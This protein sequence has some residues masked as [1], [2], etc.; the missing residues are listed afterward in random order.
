MK[1]C[2]SRRRLRC[3]IGRSARIG[4]T[5]ICRSA[6]GSFRGSTRC[7]A[8][9]RMQFAMR[10]NRCNMP[11]GSPPFY[12]GYAHEAV[13][14]A[15]SILG[16]TPLF[17]EHL[18]QARSL[19]ATVPDQNDRALL[20]ADLQSLACSSLTRPLSPAPCSLLPFQHQHPIRV[21]R[22]VGV[23]AGRGELMGAGVRQRRAVDGAELA[24]SRIVPAGD[25]RAA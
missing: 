9:A 17:Q 13:A 21:A 3:G 20:E 5:R 18:Q 25:R 6:T 1:R 15:A 12:V 4:P 22:A 11:T 23:V 14:R 19:A 2:C 7:S 24:G 16:N 10:S 8:A